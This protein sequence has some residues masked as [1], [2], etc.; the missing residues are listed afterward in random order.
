[1]AENTNAAP[2]NAAPG[3]SAPM[4]QKFTPGFRKPGQ[5]GY[6]GGDDKNV[7]KIRKPIKKKSCAFCIEKVEIIDYKDLPRLR[8][9]ISEA[10]KIVPRRT[11]GVCAKHQR[12]LATSIKRARQIALLPFVSD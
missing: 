11:S 9:Y 2:N 5:G 4:G 6:G 8:K 12:E 3:A 10:G 7:K 1:M